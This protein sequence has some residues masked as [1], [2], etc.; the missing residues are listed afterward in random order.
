[1]TVSYDVP[2]TLACLIKVRLWPVEPSQTGIGI[3]HDRSER[4]SDFMRD[5]GRHRRQTHAACNLR[6]F[7]PRTSQFLLCILELGDVGRHGIDAALVLNGLPQQPTISAVAVTKSNLKTMGHLSCGELLR[8]G[9]DLFAVV[10]MDQ[11]IRILAE[12]LPFRPTKHRSPGRIDA[13]VFAIQ[14]G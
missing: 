13:E 12:Q 1:M 5:R 2:E 11:P 14:I 10:G 7:L 3:R 8:L 9:A 6:K 4:L